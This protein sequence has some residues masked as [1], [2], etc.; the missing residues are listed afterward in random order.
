M[1]ST[2]WKAYDVQQNVPTLIG[3]KIWVVVC[4]IMREPMGVFTS[5]KKAKKF[6]KWV[7]KDSF[8]LKRSDLSIWDVTIEE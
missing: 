2:D 5:K 4:E 3:V 1:D 7:T 8:H 6:I